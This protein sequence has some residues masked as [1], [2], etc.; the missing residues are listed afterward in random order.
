[1]L[2]ILQLPEK[3]WGINRTFVSSSFYFYSQCSQFCFGFCLLSLLTTLEP[4]LVILCKWLFY[5]WCVILCHSA[6]QYCPV[7]YRTRI[8]I[9]ERMQVCWWWGKN[10]HSRFV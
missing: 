1:M 4:L 6:L 10:L 3:H 7:Y 9:Y 2:G 5:Y 8:G